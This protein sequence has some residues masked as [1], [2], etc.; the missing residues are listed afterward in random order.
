MLKSKRFRLKSH[1]GTFYQTFS[2]LLILH[3]IIIDILER[4]E[5]ILFKIQLL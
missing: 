4:G 1:Q 5:T 2:L 3:H